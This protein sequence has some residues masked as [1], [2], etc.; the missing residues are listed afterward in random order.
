MP[1]V[2]QV[3]K[4]G[5][6]RTGTLVDVTYEQIVAVLGEPNI[7]DD[8]EKVRFSWGVTV[9]GQ[10]A[11]VWCWK[12]SSIFNRWSIFDPHK[13]LATAFPQECIQA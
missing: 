8:Y 1:E 10:H 13:V 9:D 4:A 3:D 2:V 11:G 7:P 6:Y 5:S 12:G